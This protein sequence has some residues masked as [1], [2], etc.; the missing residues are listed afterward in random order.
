VTLKPSEVGNYVTAD[1]SAPREQA[2][3]H[4]G[5]GAAAARPRRQQQQQH[6]TVAG[7]A[8]AGQGRHGAATGSAVQRPPGSNRA[9]AVARRSPILQ[10]RATP[11]FIAGAGNGRAGRSSGEPRTYAACGNRRYPPLRL[12][13]QA[14]DGGLCGRFT[15]PS[16]PPSTGPMLRMPWESE[17]ALLPRMTG[18]LG[19]TS[20]TGRSVQ[21]TPNVWSP[22]ASPPI[23]TGS[24]TQ[25]G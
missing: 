11:R 17:T 18:I 4:R 1:T 24:L 14:P 22:K 19:T 5:P 21:S 25:T 16:G 2:G 7:S 20:T 6:R 23:P 15:P 9:A 12:A 13:A 10:R 3:G 8:T